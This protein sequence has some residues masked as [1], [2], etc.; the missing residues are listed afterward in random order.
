MYN[1]IHHVVV[2][3][4]IFVHMPNWRAAMDPMLNESPLIKQCTSLCILWPNC[5]ANLSDCLI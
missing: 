3:G 4:L 1:K 2:G 5:C